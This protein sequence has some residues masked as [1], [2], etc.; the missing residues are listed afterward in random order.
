MVDTLIWISG[1]SSG[2]GA[3]LAATVPFD[4]AHVVD[5]SVDGGVPGTEHLPADLADPAAWA[6]V[7]AH[8][9]ARLGDFE[10]A[11]AVFLHAAGVS[12][13]GAPPAE[14]AREEE[15]RSQRA[16]L[17]HAA[18]PQALGHAFLAAARAFSGAASLLLLVPSEVG[19]PGDGAGSVGYPV[20]VAAALQ[21]VRTAG[22]E[23]SQ[24]P[25]PVRVLAATGSFDDID[26]SDGE[27]GLAR[28]IWSLL[29][30]DLD[31]GA[32]V[33]LGAVPDQR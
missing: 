27:H 16:V 26:A 31:N 32:V 20:G 2:I 33:D 12:A 23:Q 15:G 14:E 8:L 10:G 7:E 3:A 25:G 4:D 11:R 24:R 18:A 29:D 17:L 22:K 9:V 28:S 6:A 19:D 13:P 1:A 21:W 5:I 30:Q